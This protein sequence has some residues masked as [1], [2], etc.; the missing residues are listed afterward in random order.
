MD[1]PLV[2]QF[3]IASRNLVLIRL[4]GRQVGL[5]L[6]SGLGICKLE[7]DRFR[8]IAGYG[9]TKLAKK[10]LEIFPIPLVLSTA[11]AATCFTA[12]K[13]RTQRSIG[14]WYRQVSPVDRVSPLLG[15]SALK[16]SLSREAP[17]PN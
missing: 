16:Q 7:Q 6:N 11:F 12:T 15:T 2:I 1:T 9:T 17:P 10:S 13:L 5:D 4:R 3:G 14:C 8:P